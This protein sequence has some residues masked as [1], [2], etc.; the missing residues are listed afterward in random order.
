MINT[1]APLTGWALDS[2]AELDRHAPGFAGSYLRASDERRQVIAA[3]LAVA[4]IPFDDGH[5]ARLSADFLGGADHRAILRAGFGSVPVGLRGALARSGPQPLDRRYYER[6][7][8]L[9]MRPPHRE[10]VRTI[11][12][13]PQLDHQRLRI[14]QRLPAQVCCANVVSVITS[15][16]E[17][18]DVAALI[19]LLIA[20]G[21]DADGLFAAI[22]KV[23]TARALAGVWQRW[24][25]QMTFGVHPV[26]ASETYLPIVGANDLRRLGLRFNNCAE[27]YIVG[28]LNGFDAFAEFKANNKALVVHLRRKRE[29]WMIEGMFG[30]HNACPPPALRA[31]AIK[32]LAQHG[33]GEKPPRESPSGEWE[34]LNRLAHPFRFEL[35]MED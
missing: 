15:I 1:I 27:R 21:A 24:S 33:V 3:Y 9:L 29:H 12:Q 31:E 32:Y 5:R 23:E 17:A 10:I 35:E 19:G 4:P 18:H 28:C 8:R 34:V 6:L 14:A 7:F 2:V 30:K 13:L 22:R 20:N 11:N 16:K 26:P 25:R